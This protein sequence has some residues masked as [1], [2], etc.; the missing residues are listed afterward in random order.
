MTKHLSTQGLSSADIKKL[1]RSGKVFY[2]GIP[3]SDGGREVDPSQVTF[4]ENATKL[5]PGRDLFIVHKDDAMVVVWKP[6]GMLSVYAGKKG[7]HLNVIGLVSKITGGKTFAVHRIDEGTSGLMMVARTERAQKHIKDQLEVHTVERKYIAFALGKPPE[8][9]WFVENYLV[10]DRGDGRRGSTKDEPQKEA[11]RAKTYF[12]HIESIGGRAHLI[13]AKLETGRT[14]QVRIH[15]SEGRLP[16]FGD[17]RYGTAASNRGVKHM[18]LHALSLGFV[19]PTTGKP[20]H[21]MS[22]LPDHMEKIRRRFVYESENPKHYP[23]Q[24][25]NRRRKR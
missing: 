24:T 15:L 6:A 21:F 23:K 5:T 9:S 2:Q 14:H 4:R 16:I 17:D 19:H 20:L 13:E 12:T 3:T 8:K 18:C 22:P 11:K 10:P 1:L 7:G 25:N